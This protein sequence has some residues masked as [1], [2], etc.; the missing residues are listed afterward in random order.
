MKLLHRIYQCSRLSFKFKT[1]NSRNFEVRSR[2]NPA[3]I[4]RVPVHFYSTLSD[5]DVKRRTE[6]LTDCFMEARE[7]LQDAKESL[8]TVYF[9]EDMQEAS[10]AVAQ[11]IQTYEKFLNELNETQKKDVTRTIGLKMAELKAQYAAM[12]EELKTE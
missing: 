8:N 11:T 9:S 1:Y 5:Q 7:L 2:V 4:N 12:E 3:V 6:E 10:E